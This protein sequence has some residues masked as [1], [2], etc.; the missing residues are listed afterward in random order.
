[1]WS[2]D[3]GGGWR[4]GRT[5]VVGLAVSNINMTYSA[6]LARAVME[7]PAVDHVAID[8]DAGLELA[9]RH[10]LEFG[11]RRVAFVGGSLD[12]AGRLHVGRCVLVRR[13]PTAL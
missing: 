11:R 10:L 4:K 13:E 5:G 9:T 7:D 1:M 6:E 2:G 3:D 12:G 8:N